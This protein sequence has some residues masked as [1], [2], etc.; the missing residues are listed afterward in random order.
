[1]GAGGRRHRL[2]VMQRVSHGAEKYG[3]GSLGNDIVMLLQQDSGV[4][5]S[6]GDGG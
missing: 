1:M 6:S 3:T 4:S 5:K 2:P